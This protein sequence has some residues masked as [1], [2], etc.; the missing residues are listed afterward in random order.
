MR[1]LT[2]TET[3]LVKPL[4]RRYLPGLGTEVSALGAGCW[5]LGGPATNNGIPIGWDD[6]DEEHAAH[7]ALEHAYELGITLYDTAD[8]YGLGRSERRLSHLIRQVPRDRLVISSKVGYFAGTSH[9]PYRPA[10]MRHQL[11]TTLDNLGTDHLDLYFFHSSDFGDRDHYLG[12]AIAVIH[13]FRDEGLVR[14]VGMRAPHVFAEEWAT[15]D[16]PEAADVARFLDLFAAIQPQV[17]AARYNLLSPLYDA[18]ETDIFTFARR[19]HVGVLIKQALGQGLLLGTHNPDT[20]P[21]FSPSDHRCQDA[22]F[23]GPALRTLTRRLGPIHARF[24]DSP[25]ALARVALRYALQHAPDAVVLVGFRNT[26]QIHTN[27][28]CLGDPLTD[29]ETAEIRTMLHPTPAER[30]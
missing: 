26:A 7:A 6:V 27:I 14:A 16:G 5:T 22:K 13:D 21:T 1:H 12:D 11:E 24:G 30:A 8:V 29:D 28:T 25:A 19:H 18:G 15:E 17:V 2:R 9:H 4:E 23:T 10:Q 20:P 3:T